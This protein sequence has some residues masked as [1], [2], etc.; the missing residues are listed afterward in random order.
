M[1]NV[2]IGCGPFP[3]KRKEALKQ[4]SIIELA[5]A[6]MEPI[7]HTTLR[8]W[9][10]ERPE[11]FKYVLGAWRWLTLEPL[12][13]KSAPPLDFPKR[14][15]GLFRDTPANRAVWAEIRGQA[16]A[17]NADGVLFRSPAAFTPSKTNIDSLRH[18]RKEIIGDVPF[19]LLWEA[20]G[21]WVEDEIQALADELG[22]TLVRD[23]HADTQFPMPSESGYY[24]IT[25]PSGHLRFSEDDLFDLSDFLDAHPADVRAV[26]RGPDRQH[27]AHALL[28]LR[29]KLAG[30]SEPGDD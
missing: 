2:L 20:R 22:F 8:A 5:E 29:R 16:D 26:F 23:P 21:M 24:A 13:E 12:D 30:E 7:R 4:F 19:E 14:D 18:F 27:N 25:A 11:G 1:P 17:L 10:A 28:K 3:P 9:N 15:F 6:I